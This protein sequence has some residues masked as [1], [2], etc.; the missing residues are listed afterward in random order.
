METLYFGKHGFHSPQKIHL[1]ENTINLNKLDEIAQTGHAVIDL[2]SMG[3]T[4]LLGTGK[5]TRALTITV[6]ACSKIAE[7][8]IA[9]AGGK[10]NTETEEAEAAEPEQ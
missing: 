4:K 6:P 10:V 3:Y 8:K 5:I 9:A 7:K 2:T 1:K